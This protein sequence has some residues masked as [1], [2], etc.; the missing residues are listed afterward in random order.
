MLPY[1][2]GLRVG[3]HQTMALIGDTKRAKDEGKSS[4][5]E[6]GLTGPLSV[7]NHRLPGSLKEP[8]TVF[9]R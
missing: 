3:A 6:T 1:A 7:D 8:K 2:R 5:V 4:L 9:V